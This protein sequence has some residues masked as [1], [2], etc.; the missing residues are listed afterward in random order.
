MSDT[1]YYDRFSEQNTEQQPLKT[2]KEKTDSSAVL[3][4]AKVFGYMFIGLMITAVIA[5]GLGYYFGNVLLA[6]ASTE[7]EVRIQ[8]TN[9]IILLVALGVSL[10]GIIVLSKVS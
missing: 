3:S 1:E 5:L 2:K 9:V 7:M 8:E 10:I 4:I 6:E